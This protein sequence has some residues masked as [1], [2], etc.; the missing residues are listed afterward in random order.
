M[1]GLTTARSKRS[2]GHG[3]APPPAG[4]AARACAPALALR[5]RP[6]RLDLDPPREQVVGKRQHQ[7]H[8]EREHAPRRQQQAPQHRVAGEEGDLGRHQ[9]PCQALTVRETSSMSLFSNDLR[10]RNRRTRTRPGLRSMSLRS[11]TSL[12]SGTFPRLTSTDISRGRPFCPPA[13]TPR[14][15]IPPTS[16]PPLRAVVSTKVISAG[17]LCRSFAS[18]SWRS[19]SCA[20][21]P[22]DSC[23]IF[24]KSARFSSSAASARPIA[25]GKLAKP[26]NT[27]NRRTGPAGS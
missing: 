26:I 19:C 11:L 6:L 10:R 17:G 21:Y 7:E 2:S 13:T 1:S 27:T 24:S 9:D 12:S 16:T 23:E 4:Q 18:R 15:L 14:S 8:E 20:P 25:G 22:A 5:A 3:S